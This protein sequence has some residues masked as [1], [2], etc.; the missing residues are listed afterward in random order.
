MEEREPTK[1]FS[2][3]FAI[4]IRSEWESAAVLQIVEE[5][6]GESDHGNG[7]EEPPRHR[8]VEWHS[9]KLLGI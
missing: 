1:T 8:T 9:R 5:T 4:E 6:P 7:E 2:A 3:P